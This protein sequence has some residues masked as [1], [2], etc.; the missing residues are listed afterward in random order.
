MQQVPPEQEPVEERHAT[1]HPLSAEAERV[2]HS[3]APRLFLDVFSGTNAPLTAAML[4]A[5]GDCFVPFDLDH[6]AQHNILDDGMF[7]LLLRI[8]WSGI[9]GA[10]WAAPPCKEFSR[11][12]LRRPGPKAL[13]TPDPDAPIDFS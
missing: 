13:R 6:N 8:C 7:H 11:L 1:M 4:E 2:E 5:E 12:K 10:I 9:V 3:K